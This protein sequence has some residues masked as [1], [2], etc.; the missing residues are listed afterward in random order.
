[1]IPPCH[2]IE[3][4]TQYSWL[5]EDG[6]VRVRIKPHVTVDLADAEAAMRASVE[7]LGASRG[8]LLVDMTDARELTRDAR[9]YFASPV[10]GR[11]HSGVGL[12]VRSPVARAIGNFFLGINR[13]II[14]TRLFYDEECAATWLATVPG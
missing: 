10:S 3:L 11:C 12:I 6:I 7:L 8:P 14:P 4:R 5:G 1:M 9:K 2:A 13:P